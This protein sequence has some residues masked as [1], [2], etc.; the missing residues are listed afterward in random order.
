MPLTFDLSTFKRTLIAVT[1]NPRR[2][3]HQ[4]ASIFFGVTFRRLQWRN[5]ANASTVRALLYQ[6]ASPSTASE[7]LGL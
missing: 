7:R 5:P 1:G 6:A 3:N 4:L 2:S